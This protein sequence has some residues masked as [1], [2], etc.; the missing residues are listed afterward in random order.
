MKNI[1]KFAVVVSLFSIGIAAQVQLPRE[2]QRQE[3]VQTVG[4]ATIRVVYHR[5][6]VKGR[7]IWDGLVPYGKVWRA[8]ANEATLFEFSRDVTVNGQPLPA[9]KYSFHVIPES[10]EWTLI[11]NKDDGQWGSFSYDAAKDALRVRSSIE[12]ALFTES[13]TYTFGKVDPDGVDVYL[14]WENVQVPF[15]IGIGNIHGR[16]LSQIREGLAG[17]T[18]AERVP[19][20]NQFAN[21]VATFKLKDHLDEALT[22]I[23]ASIAARET[24]SNNYTKARLMA[25]KGNYREAVRLGEKAL[26]MGPA[27]T[28]P[29]NPN[30]L[31]LIR[32]TVAEWKAK[33]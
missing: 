21:Y 7:K 8:G 12:K 6:N 29:A 33:M 26:E 14:I 16:I 27:A 13:L 2:S 20:L 17:K 23:D 18:G 32:T 9:G 15:R 1:I 10:R 30:F 11:F 31:D 24:F 3:V 22:N 5:P 19:L 4:D 25:E 28:P